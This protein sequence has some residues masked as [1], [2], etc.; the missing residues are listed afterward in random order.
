MRD[1]LEMIKN[2]K[3]KVSKLGEMIDDKVKIDLPDDIV[4][5]IEALGD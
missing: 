1:L 2:N 5:Q 4:S 3:A